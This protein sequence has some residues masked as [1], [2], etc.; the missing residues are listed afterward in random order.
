D[1]L[2]RQDRACCYVPFDVSEV[3]LRESAEQLLRDYAWLDVHAIVGDYDRHLGIIP[4]GER[5]LYVF[6]GGTIGNFEPLEA[7]RFLSSLS[8]SMHAGDALLLGT[9][10]IKDHVRLNAAY[11][12]EQGVT[13]AFNRNVLQVIN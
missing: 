6:L 3:T 8:R 12:D 4:G 13:A 9:D 10:L 5:R 2:E 7:T 11:N 1:E